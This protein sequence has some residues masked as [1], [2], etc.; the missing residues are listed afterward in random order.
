[1]PKE[2]DYYT[3]GELADLFN[4]PKQTLLYYDKMGIL[5]PEFISDNNYRHYSL[6]QYLILEV[7]VNMR[8]LGIPLTQIKNYLQDRSEA[9]FTKLLQN[10]EQECLEII[11]HNK[12]IL[13]DIQ[14]AYRQLKKLRE[15]RLDQITVTF[16]PAKNFFLS[17]IAPSISGNEVIAILAKHNLTVFSKKHFKE[18]AVG[19]ILPKDDFV[20]GV[21]GKVA[22]FF[23]TLNPG[24]HDLE[25]IYTRPDGLYMTMRFK[26]TVRSNIKNLSQKFNDYMRRNNLR[27]VDDVY[28]MPLKNSWLTAD[29][30][31]YVYQISLR[32]EAAPQNYPDAQ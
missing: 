28:V 4:L 27:P 9:N 8:K 20:R 24:Y 22:A 5:S 26:G 18:R 30:A 16:R 12:K 29:T 32:V 7:I 11:A 15:S 14:I 1:M 2:N 25:N 19:W 21:H 17:P 13:D 10:K 3:A 6:K 23:S 31:E